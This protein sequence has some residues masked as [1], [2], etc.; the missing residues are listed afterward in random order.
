MPTIL[1][2]RHAENDYVKKGRL[3]G[4]LPAV[5]LNERGREQAEALAK[6]LSKAPIKAVYS[7]PLDRT[8]ETIAA[9]HADY[10]DP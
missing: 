5:H 8:I 2:I 10:L 4:R 3:A 6:S 7:S 9:M 1:L